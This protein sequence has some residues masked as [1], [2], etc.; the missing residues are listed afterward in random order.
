MAGTDHTTSPLS[1]E[2][3]RQPAQPQRLDLPQRLRDFLATDPAADLSGSG[4]AVEISA[5]FTGEALASFAGNTAED[6]A[7][8]TASAREAAAEWAA[9]GARERA[10]VIRRLADKVRESEELLLDV[11]QAENGKG[12]LHAFDELMH[13]YMLARFISGRGPKILAEQSAPGA[14]PVLTTTRIRRSPVGVV[15]F[16]SPWNYPLSLGGV[17]LLSALLAG[18]AVVHKPDS[19][20]PLS[21]VLM[22]SLAVEAGMP[23]DVWQLVPGTVGEVGD[24]LIDAA[25]GLSFTGSTAAGKQIASKV[26]GQLKPMALELGGKNPLLVLEDADVDRAVEGALRAAFSSTGQLCISAERIYVH[27][28]LYARFRD[29]FAEAARKLVL[30]AGFDY[31]YDI[32]SLSHPAQ[33]ERV[34]QHVAQAVSAGA[35]VLAGGRAR[36]EIGP[37]FYEP[38]VLEGV[39]AEADLFASE[40]FGPVV[41]LYPVDS[42]EEAIAAANATEYG[43]SA[44]V[45]SRS[46]RHGFDV[47]RQIEAGMVNINEAF[48][49]AFGS[50]AAPSGGVKASGLGGRHGE[51]GLLAF[52]ETHTMAHQALVPLAPFGDLIPGLHV[53]PKEF[54][55]IISGS[56]KVMAKLRL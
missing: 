40:T 43:L 9:A 32:G 7:R 52:T 15:G 12:R 13:F 28:S 1:S 51:Q 56:L 26:A 11:I 3:S 37:L 19:K 23:A 18:N 31:S 49:A 38:T 14:F 42:D 8:K 33:L 50:V 5:P 41:A 27:S 47:A 44:S 16:I 30:G 46:K 10:R 20:T 6:V 55:K 25:D 4:E 24:A 29:Q 21:A 54:Q 48:A 34:E 53:G 22:R 35:R 17:D 2:T 45:W 39:T 36:P